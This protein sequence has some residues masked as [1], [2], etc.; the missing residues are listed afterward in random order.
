[1]RLEAIPQ[2]TTGASL[3]GRR[4]VRIVSWQCDNRNDRIPRAIGD[5]N[6]LIIRF[7]W[8]LCSVP[9]RFRNPGYHLSRADL[10]PTYEHGT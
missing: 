9:C 7:S 10:R 6:V 1:M 8:R 4:S 3:L 2:G 5:D